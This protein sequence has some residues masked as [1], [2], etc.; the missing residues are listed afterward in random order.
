MNKV[1]VAAVSILKRLYQMSFIRLTICDICTNY[2][3]LVFSVSENV[4]FLL[5]SILYFYESYFFFFFKFIPPFGVYLKVVKDDGIFF[6]NFS[7]QTSC[8]FSKVFFF[9]FDTVSDMDR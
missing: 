8:D 9:F 1:L 7:R 2:Q 5:L 4:L 6:Q 3:Q